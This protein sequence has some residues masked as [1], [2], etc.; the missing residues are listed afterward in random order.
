MSLYY[1]AS[2]QELM[3]DD[4]NPACDPPCPTDWRLG[5]LWCT[6]CIEEYNEEYND[7]LDQVQEISD[8]I[9]KERFTLPE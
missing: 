4:I 3:D 2:C 7:W 9:R 6:T 1:C 8:A 5:E